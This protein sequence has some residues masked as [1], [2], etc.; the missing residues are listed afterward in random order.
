RHGALTLLS[1]LSLSA[2]AY[3]HG[4]H[5]LPQAEGKSE[6]DLFH[7]IQF[8]PIPSMIF[9]IPVP[10]KRRSA[11]DAVQAMHTAGIVLRVPAR[12]RIHSARQRIT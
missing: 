9:R 5:S 11:N 1:R 8:K 3:G 7:C 12:A 2:S 10:E 4:V 6:F